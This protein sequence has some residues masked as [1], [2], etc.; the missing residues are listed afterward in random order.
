MTSVCR[1]D[2]FCPRLCRRLMDPS[3]EC[4]LV[5]NPPRSLSVTG[6]LFCTAPFAAGGYSKAYWC[7]LTGIGYIFIRQSTGGLDRVRDD[8][9][10]GLRRLWTISH[11]DL[12]H[13][14]HCRCDRG[15]LAP[16][17]RFLVMR[18]SQSYQSLRSRGGIARSVIVG[19]VETLRE[20]IVSAAQHIG[21]MENVLQNV[22][23]WPQ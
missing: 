20:P 6:V 4:G 5:P 18:T 1:S 9:A 2:G 17:I 11:G 7:F 10:M 23:F 3:L 21:L 22:A 16:T 14:R 15:G 12:D 13:S 19:T 8:G